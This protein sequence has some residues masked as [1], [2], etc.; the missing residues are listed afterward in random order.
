MKN[1]RIYVLVWLLCSHF[2][3]F[4]AP[5]EINKI[6][7]IVNDSVILLSDLNHRLKAIKIN[8]NNI[9]QSLPDDAI[10]RHQILERLIVESIQ[11]QIANKIGLK[12]PDED[13]DKI[14]ADIAR[15]NRLTVDQIR[16]KLASE[17]INYGTY[18]NEIRNQILISEVLKNAVQPRI[19]ILPQ[20]VDSLSKLILN[21]KN[22]NME[23]NLSQI[24]IPLTENPSQKE[25]DKAEKKAN[26]LVSQ[27]KKGA[28]FAKLAI[29]YSAD[30]QAFKGG[31]MGWK[32]VQEL[33][34]LFSEKLKVIHK[35]DIIGPIR[36]GVGFHI[37]R[38]NDLHTIFENSE[39]IKNQA[40]KILFN[41]KFSEQA[42]T[43]IQE[44]RASAY[45]KIL[46]HD[47]E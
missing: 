4:S 9:N 8:A 37:L 5:K 19:N 32:K 1:W 20:E 21:E 43:W 38:I 18:R 26:K 35:F 47:D 45:V 22:Q 34:T 24:L 40:Y 2:T 17:N 39:D 44:Q 12:I 25:I 14:I 41:R 11:L 31:M 30:S 46:E 13:L 16:S 23:L 42:E 7:A 28:N 15:K 36:S 10:L 29:T 3:V 33:P 27:L 6:V